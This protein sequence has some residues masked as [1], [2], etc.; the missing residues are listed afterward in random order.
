M[1]YVLQIFTGGFNNKKWHT[2]D[3]VERLNKVIRILDVPIIILGWNINREQIKELT[4]FLKSVGIKTYY[5]APIFSEIGSNVEMVPALNLQKTKVGSFSLSKDENFEFYCPSNEKNILNII[6]F[7]KSN[8][9]GL[10]IDG[11]FLDKI[12][13]QSFVNGLSDGISCTCDKCNKFYESKGFDISKFLSE[14]SN[15]SSIMHPRK[16]EYPLEFEDPFTKEYYNIK[17]DLYFSSIKQIV[18]SFKSDGY[19][20]GLDTF[21]PTIAQ[22][23][24]Q[25]ISRLINISDFVKPMVYEIT[26]APAG[27]G[28]EIDKFKL[29]INQL[30]KVDYYPKKDIAI[31]PNKN[32]IYPGIEINTIEG[33]CDNSPKYVVSNVDYYQSFGFDTVTLSWDLMS[34]N[35]ET[36]SLLG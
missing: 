35:M 36:F 13:S 30:D 32:K 17:S 16:F 31:L 19:E 26:K 2:L 6:E 15:K 27:V 12:R 5:W 8:L 14:I 7:Y 20:I 28:F 18:D 25:D 3:I 1:K 33:I 4:S 29:A 22:L 21:A 23:V 10:G 24:G 34:A 9:K 11:I